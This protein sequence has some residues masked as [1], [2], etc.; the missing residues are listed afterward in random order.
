MRTIFFLTLFILLSC[1]PNSSILTAQQIVDKSIMLSG[2]DKV[3]S[4]KIVFTFRKRTYIAKRNNGVYSLE[5]VAQKDAIE[6]K[7]VLSNKGFVRYQNSELMHV[8]DSMVT[9]YSNSVNSV[10][11]FSVLPFGLNDKA[12]FKKRLSDTTIKGIDYYKIQV[13]FSEDGGGDDFDDVFLYWIKKDN[14]QIDYLAY[15]YNTGK[16][17]MRFRDV[18]NESVVSGIRFVNYNNYKPI[19]SKINFFLIEKAYQDGQLK[20]IS[21]IILENI[22]VTLVNL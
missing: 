7:D 17:G 15:K 5:R 3:A 9:R 21:E 16:G 14:F 11:Y 13:T 18:K 6:I 10:H 12:V 8:P 19:N 22:K 2:A 1:K 4:S 20:K